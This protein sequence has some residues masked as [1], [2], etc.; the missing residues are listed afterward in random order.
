MDSGGFYARRSKE[1]QTKGSKKWMSSS[2]YQ[3][4]EALLGPNDA[5][6]NPPHEL[7]SMFFCSLAHRCDEKMKK[8]GGGGMPTWGNLLMD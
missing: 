8:V 1:E 3:Q 6:L 7:Y 2:I 5:R 4:A